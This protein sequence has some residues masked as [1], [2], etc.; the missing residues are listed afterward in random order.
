MT[1]AHAARRAANRSPVMLDLGTEQFRFLSEMP[2]S[3]MLGLDTLDNGSNT[4]V[5]AWIEAHL[6]VDSE[7][8]TSC[9]DDG[10]PLL[11]RA[12]A[13]ED[14][15]R[16]RLKKARNADGSPVTSDEFHAFHQ[17]I[18]DAH[19][20][21]EGESGSSAGSSP[22][23]GERSNGTAPGPALTVQGSGSTVR[24]VPDAS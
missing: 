6:Q 16:S 3:I 22:T 17:A 8:D 5:R 7:C 10:L 13:T 4:E 20:V 12:C 24:A 21:T 14:T 19:A 18:L 9:A 15:Y 1:E 23:A 11:A 2:L